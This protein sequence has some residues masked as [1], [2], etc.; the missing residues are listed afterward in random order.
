MSKTLA[1]SSL[2]SKLGSPEQVINHAIM[3][4]L[5]ESGFIGHPF[6]K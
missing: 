4:K 2:Y 3:K 5:D 1:V 6:G